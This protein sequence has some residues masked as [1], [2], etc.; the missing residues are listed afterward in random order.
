MEHWHYNPEAGH[1]ALIGLIIGAV[2]SQIPWLI[3]KMQAKR[4]PQQSNKLTG[5]ALADWQAKFD[6]MEHDDPF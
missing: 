3:E 5:Q 1:I 6:A 4:K 2:A